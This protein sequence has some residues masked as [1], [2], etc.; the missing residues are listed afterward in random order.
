[1][2][3]SI[4]NLMAI[5]LFP[6]FGFSQQQKS[7]CLQI[8]ANYACESNSIPEINFRANG[9]IYKIRGI[10]FAEGS[11]RAN[12]REQLVSY[13]PGGLDRDAPYE[14]YIKA[15]CT[16]FGFEIQTR[17]TEFSD[18]DPATGKYKLL[19][20]LTILY[21]IAVA[22]GAS[23]LSFQVTERYAEISTGIETESKRNF[24]C[25]KVSSQ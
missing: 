22:S 10:P 25:K 5:L 13:F 16:S 21:R 4:S 2:K 3:L 17:N 18:L 15:V 9:E 11:F 6:V 24:E 19:G 8:S 12:G 14:A 7:T 1:M 20:H 23:R